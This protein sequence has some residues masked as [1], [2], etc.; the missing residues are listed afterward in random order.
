MGV[1]L[2]E[3]CLTEEDGITAN[4]SCPTKIPESKP[5]EI[6]PEK[7]DALINLN[8]FNNVCGNL[9]SDCVAVLER[10]QD[11]YT[12]LVTSLLPQGVSYND[13]VNGKVP[14]KLLIFSNPEINKGDSK[15]L[16][17]NLFFGDQQL[18]ILDDGTILNPKGGE[19]LNINVAQNNFLYG[20][21]NM[22][23][24]Q[25][26][27]VVN[28]RS[29]EPLLPTNNGECAQKSTVS[30]TIVIG[31][32]NPNHDGR[33]DLRLA[34]DV[35]DKDWAPGQSSP[36]SLYKK[37]D[38]D[39]DIFFMRVALSLLV[40]QLLDQFGSLEQGVVYYWNPS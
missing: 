19:S 28:T 30:D 20:S 7:I 35:I 18:E 38:D 6:K 4:E 24:E 10:L 14:F 36:G 25:S 1:R 9:D 37:Y 29:T 2:L 8:V 40:D 33:D 27:L 12:E 32:G 15:S 34:L 22:V 3:A 16:T 26:S 17:V 21:D 11:T 31:V 5:L 23:L 39:G 13:W